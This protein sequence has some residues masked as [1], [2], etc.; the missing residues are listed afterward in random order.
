MNI[1]FRVDSDKSRPITVLYLLSKGSLPED[2]IK[3]NGE[4]M[5]AIVELGRNF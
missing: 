4:S 1:Q 2:I 5:R 3:S